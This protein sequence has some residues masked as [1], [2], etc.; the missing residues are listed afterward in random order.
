VAK[1]EVKNVDLLYKSRNQYFTA[2]RD[3]SFSV[4][5]GDFV[6]VIGPSGCGKTTLL[7]LLIGLLKPTAGQILLDG[8]PLTG[9]GKERSAVVQ[10]YSLVPWMTGREKV[11]FAMKQVKNAKVK[12]LKAMALEHLNA[13]GLAAFYD[14]FP[15][16]LSGGM[17]QRV[18]IVRALAT[19]PQILL[20]DEPFGAVDPK[21]RATLH[22]LLLRLWSASGKKRTIIFIT[23]DID[24]A[25]LL[26]DY[27]IALSSGPGAVEDI[28]PITLERPRILEII[29]H[30]PLYTSIRN[31]ILPLFY[32]N[33]YGAAAKESRDE[34][35]IFEN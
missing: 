23:H 20:M 35:N 34:N 13:V 15:A 8:A 25:I 7:R 32:G 26:S 29:V 21:N 16:E 14:K 1:I 10:E 24:E 18:A 30:N 22:E 4:A 12:E 5:E 11:T 9:T 17:Q 28:I 3:V 31:R 2:L 19:D 27:V 33:A 6:S